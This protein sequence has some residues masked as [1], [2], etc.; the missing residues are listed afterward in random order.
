LC[1]VEGVDAVQRALG[2]VGDAVLEQVVG[3]ELALAGGDSSSRSAALRSTS[4]VN[5]IHQNPT[6]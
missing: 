4:T 2:E 3:G 6:R 1:E 5:G